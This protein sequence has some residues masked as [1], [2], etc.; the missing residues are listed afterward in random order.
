[1]IYIKQLTNLETTAD[2]IQNIAI[3]R[4]SKKRKKNEF[5][6]QQLKT[7]LKIICAKKPY[8]D[9]IRQLIVYLNDTHDKYTKLIY[10]MFL[11]LKINTSCNERLFMN[12]WPTEDN[13]LYYVW[14]IKNKLI[15]LISLINLNESS[16]LKTQDLTTS[17]ADSVP[18]LISKDYHGVEIRKHR[19][20]IWK[21]LHRCHCLT[22]IWLS[23]I[24][25]LC[26]RS[27][28]TKNNFFIWK[29]FI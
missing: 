28:C 17:D 2:E 18:N 22:P 23:T 4:M 8:I 1:M 9:S 25:P 11:K 21:T 14:E 27:E 16:N 20:I 26:V 29:I 15:D 6:D 10:R 19:V 13:V 24:C 7:Y 5:Q 12:N 3:D